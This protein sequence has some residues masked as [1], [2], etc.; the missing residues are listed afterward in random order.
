MQNTAK[1]ASRFKRPT[2]KSLKKYDDFVSNKLIIKKASLEGALCTRFLYWAFFDIRRG[3]TERSVE[4]G[5]SATVDA[6]CEQ[7]TA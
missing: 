1:Q 5:P 3:I 4:M 7:D 2:E 6:K